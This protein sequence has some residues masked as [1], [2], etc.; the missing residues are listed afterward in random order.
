MRRLFAALA[1]TLAASFAVA[2]A[3]GAPQSAEMAAA[4][5]PRATPAYAALVLRK[6]A[7]EAELSGLSSQ[8]TDE[9]PRVVAKRFELAA[10]GREMEAMRR[11]GREGVRMLSRSYGE[12]VL[13]K[14]ALEVELQ[15]L[16]AGYTPEHPDVIKK[17]AQLA[18]LAR[19]LEEMLR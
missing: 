11:V 8:L 1:F 17:E 13:G 3:N 9:S 4:D 6:A 16:L 5:D 14:V 10:V 18:A 7:V 15:S 12:L 19:E 2:A